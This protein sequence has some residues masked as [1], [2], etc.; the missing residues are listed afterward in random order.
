MGSKFI[1]LISVL[2]MLCMLVAVFAACGDEDG[3][4]NGNETPKESQSE[5]KNESESESTIE[6]VK[7]EEAWA[8]LFDEKLFENFK[9]SAT[10]I[11]TQT[12][13]GVEFRMDISV[14]G[15]RDGNKY[16]TS[17]TT[18]M[19]QMLDT[20]T[21]VDYQVIEDDMLYIY[22][23]ETDGSWT[24]MEQEAPEEMK[25]VEFLEFKFKENFSKFSFDG[26]YYV[27]DNYDTS[28]ED[29][30]GESVRLTVKSAKIKVADG[31]IAEVEYVYDVID[32]E[33]AWT[34]NIKYSIFD[35]GKAVVTLP[36]VSEKPEDPETNFGDKNDPSK[37]TSSN[38][39]DNSSNN[40]DKD[41]GEKETFKPNGDGEHN[42]DED[43]NQGDQNDS[44]SGLTER[45]W[46][47]IF[48]AGVD[49]S[50]VSVDF[51]WKEIGTFN[52]KYDNGNVF[53]AVDAMGM[54]QKTY[55]IKDGDMATVY[56]YVD[57]V[58]ETLTVEYVFEDY[59]PAI[60]FTEFNW[61]EHFSEFRFNGQF[62]TA[63]NINVS[64]NVDGEET[65]V[66]CVYAN[67]MIYDGRVMYAEY[68]ITDV[69]GEGLAIMDVVER[70]SDYGSTFVGLP[71]EG[72]TETD[73][74]NTDK[75]NKP[76]NSGNISGQEKPDDFA[77]NNGQ[78]NSDGSLGKEEVPKYEEEL[79]DAEGSDTDE[80]EIII[81]K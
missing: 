70:Y 37:E 5:S 13:D 6:T 53:M 10:N 9:F 52:Y 21:S 57:G 7:T 77:N 3:N 46:K 56:N 47:K 55:I 45:D 49:Y 19:T 64:W 74:E 40:G 44:Q 50:N 61:G 66:V 33:S 72:D 48:E 11:S 54:L 16:Y 60:C 8:A 78:V 31:K 62:Y 73:P 58:L 22:T 12:M 42:K 38:A 81:I 2:C 41:N 29:Y 67:F 63:E 34:S 28:I 18:T 17:S 71:Q 20:Y 69:A 26:E 59:T 23:L 4:S 32:G 80:K 75:P 35:Y 76:D 30:L 27:A 79:P 36:E 14:E 15:A 43:L 1:K 39:G 65:P 68:K 24:L 25:T 51:L